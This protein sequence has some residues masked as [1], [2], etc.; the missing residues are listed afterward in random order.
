MFKFAAATL[1]GAKAEDGSKKAAITSLPAAMASGIV[2]AAPAEGP[3][4]I[5][6][7]SAVGVTRR[8]S[9]YAAA[10]LCLIIPCHCALP[11]RSSTSE[12]LVEA[13]SDSSKHTQTTVLDHVSYHHSVQAGKLGVPCV[14]HAAIF[15]GRELLNSSSDM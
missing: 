4:K 6:M 11:R 5:A 3:K 13:D 2:A 1:F 10:G 14:Q 9:C 12:L 8:L 15:R 7:H